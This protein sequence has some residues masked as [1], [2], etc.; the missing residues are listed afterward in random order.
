MADR[1]VR[2]TLTGTATPYQAAMRQ[3]ARST[4]QAA[5]AIS[6]TMMRAGARSA[7]AFSPVQAASSRAAAQVAARWQ[8]AGRSIESRF[9]RIAAAARAA[10]ARTAAGL[11]AGAGAVAARWNAVGSAIAGRWRATTGL[12]TRA[13]AGVRSA[14]GTAASWVGARWNAAAAAT[15]RAFGNMRLAAVTAG[16]HMMSVA[17]NGKKALEAARTASLGLLAAFAA[18]ALAAAKFDKGMSE[19]R[20]ATN[21]SAGGMARLRQAAIDAGNATKYS[22]SEAATAEAELAKA[23]ISTGDIIGGALKGSLA[24]AA[25]GQMDLADSAVVAAQAMNAFGLSGKDVP[26]IADV[27]SAGAGKS[28]TD[29]HNMSMAFRQ[30][31]LVASQTGLSLEDT[32]GTLAL[33]AQNALTGSDAGTSLKTMLQRLTPQS[34]EAAA[35]MDKVGFSAY[36]SQGNFVGLSEMAQRLHQSFSGLTPEARNAAFGVI[37]GSDAVRAAS[38]LYKAGGA[39]VDSWTKAVKESGYA[40]RMSA[41]MTDNLAGDWERLTSALE[42][43]LISS[44]S[45]ANGVL[46]SMAQTITGL[47]NWYNNLSPS[48][49]RGVTAFA[50]IAGVVGLAG[51][52][53]LLML[54]RIMAVRRELLAMGLTASRAR[55]M[56]GALGSV[57]GVVAGIAAVAYGVR[58]LKAELREAPPSANK[59]GQ[60]L[61]DFAKKGKASGALAKTFGS[62]LGDLSESIKQIANPS[63]ADRLD[64]M[65]QQFK[66]FSDADVMGTKGPLQL[67]EAKDKIHAVDQALTSLVQSGAQD[68]AKAAFDRLAAAAKKGG[69]STSDFKS[70]LPGYT[71]AL[72]AA[73][74]QSQT[75]GDAQKNLGDA[76]GMTKTEFQ[77]QRSAAEK[78]TDAL[79]TLNGI[80][81]TAAEQEIGFRQS[82]ADLTSTVKE[83]GHSLDTTSEKGR[84]VKSA[85]LDA[86]KAAMEHAQAVADQKGTVE[87]GNAVLEKDISALKRTMSQA[88]FT[89]TQIR[90]LTSAYA[91]L[92]GSKNTTV[93]AIQAQ[94]TMNELDTI[95]KKVQNVPAGKSITVKAPSGP[96]IAALRDIGYK[97]VTLPN[98]QV[99]ITVPTSGP[100]SSI[101]ALRR[102][103]AALQDKVV[104]IS[105]TR[106]Y[107]SV[108]NPQGMKNALETRRDGGPIGRYASGGEV[109]VYPQGGQI[110]G[111][112]TATSDSIL[113][114]FPSG[115]AMVS[116]TEYVVRAAAVRRYGLG[117]LNAINR[118]TLPKFA[119]GGAL[120]RLAAGGLNGFSYSPTGAAVLGGTGDAKERYDKDIQQLRDGWTALSKALADQ[121][122]QL[123]Q[124]RA[125][126]SKATQT[127]RDGARRVSQAEANLHRVR[128]RRHTTAQL[129]AAEDRL[130]N[131]RA[132]AAKA[133]KAAASKV[134]S[135]RADARSAAGKVGAARKA[136]NSADAALGLRRGAKAPAA[137][138]L[139]AYQKELGAS[140]AATTKWRSNLQKIAQR[141][142]EDARQML[143]DMGKD[144]Y[145]LVNSLAGASNKQFEDIIKK[146][147]QTGG[148]AQATLG[149]FTRQLGA[150]TKESNQFAADL[151]TLASRGFGDLAQALAAQGDD[152][153]ATLAHQAATGS[154]TDVAKANAAVKSH[155]Q[156]LTGD[157]LANS[158]VVL[159]AL[160]SKKGA[161]IA[162][163]IGAGVDFATLRTLV[164][165]MLAQINKLPSVYKSAFLAQWAGQSGAAAMARGG[166]LTRP[167]AV[168]AAEAG[169]AESWIPV[170]SSSRSQGLLA[171]TAGLMGYQLIPAGRYGPVQ[172]ADRR[173]AR[174]GDRNTTVNLYGARQTSAEQARDIARHLAFVG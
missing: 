66:L 68:Q 156:A 98:H 139:A 80:N 76:A 6:A 4:T 163:V 7:A 54:P 20:A 150:S 111:P 75:T 37:F 107:R 169:D 57:G 73:G 32:S 146:L 42:T 67:D 2:V 136:I 92:P 62:D 22:A 133:N 126:E 152:T 174:E 74:V 115:P 172:A 157:D 39:G 108:G 27:I 35:A 124:L 48:V 77:D 165:R 64:H 131:A 166:I 34:S 119:G 143:Q 99:R 128:S 170:N 127:R 71:D 96:A 45:S 164:P 61:L 122:K 12:V 102:Q 168:L 149:D 78:L 91:Q 171:R 41:T 58:E 63:V 19:V 159:A 130:S 70:L 47:V 8:A 72:A 97:V 109:Q 38:I 118:G 144:G 14:A 16:A 142:G 155:Q 83:N 1:T 13:M 160:R 105:I 153:A 21:E 52:A 110:R 29:V 141:G 114:L 145:A 89:E 87:A 93:K 50:G 101:A 10:G 84:K 173:P 51:S 40:A 49:Q 117:L 167:T 106:Y 103:I 28:A 137:F 95:R 79:K 129:A 53:L 43:G 5:Q 90:Q 88:G 17:T 116:D 100:A 147:K 15:G 113:A 94:Q 121:R 60:S 82:L 3:A 125:A 56:L 81:I 31:A 9:P 85:F 18:A 30:V 65:T 148:V 158:L 69:Q 33:F 151:Q 26:H 86:A 138:S 135:E 36:D 123:G 44:G 46:R 132:S 140:V 154:T 24:L 120:P 23:G 59:L 112:G 104:S 162:D 55:G 11:S 25:S 161:G 134:G